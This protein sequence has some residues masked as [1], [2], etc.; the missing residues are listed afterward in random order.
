MDNLDKETKAQIYYITKPFFEEA[1]LLCSFKNKLNWQEEG[2][3]LMSWKYQ[4]VSETKCIDL[5]KIYK[6]YKGWNGNR[7][8]RLAG[9]RSITVGDIV[10]IG[11]NVRLITGMG[12]LTIPT[13]VWK[14][15]KKV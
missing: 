6:Y 14:Y 5:N 4:K 7:H 15:I 13:Y 2:S 9:H 11:D 3:S 8:T 10:V 1:M 12:W